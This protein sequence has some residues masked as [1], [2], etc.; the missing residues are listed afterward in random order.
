MNNLLLISST[1]LGKEKKPKAARPKGFLGVLHSASDWNLEFD[2]D[3]RS[4]SLHF[5]QFCK[6]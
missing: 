3:G 2:L 1:L 4:G 6:Y 5:W